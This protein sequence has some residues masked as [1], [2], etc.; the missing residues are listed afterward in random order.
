MLSRRLPN[1]WTFG[2][3]NEVF[4]TN[5]GTTYDGPGIPPTVPVPVFASADLRAQRD[6]ALG[7]ALEL[8]TKR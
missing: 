7:K 6:P 2:L 1:G 8:L 5:D 4:L 3:P